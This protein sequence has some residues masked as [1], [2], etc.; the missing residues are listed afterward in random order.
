MLSEC[1]IKI[2]GMNYQFYDV[3]NGSRG[4]ILLFH[5]LP[6][7]KE[8]YSSLLREGVLSEKYRL[9]ALDLPGHNNIP[10]YEYTSL[11]WC[12]FYVRKL[13]DHLKLT[14]NCFL[15]GY[16]FGGEVAVTFYNMFNKDIK[17]EKIFT[18]A[19]PFVGLDIKLELLLLFIK[20]LPVSFY[21]LINLQ[22]LNYIN[23]LFRMGVPEKDIYYGTKVPKEVLQGFLIEIAK[24]KHIFNNFYPSVPMLFLFGSDD[25]LIPQSNRHYIEKLFN[26]RPDVVVESVEDIGHLCSKVGEKKRW[27]YVCDFLMK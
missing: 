11:E 8:S 13:V 16:S 18:V 20:F 6:G 10:L 2:D 19:T 27:Q 9:V 21:K 24:R 5:G 1:R 4:T 3:G 7:S 23:K 14:G 25:P 22:N 12:A 15:G 26:Q 17:I